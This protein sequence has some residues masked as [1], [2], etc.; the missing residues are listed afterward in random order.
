MS[1]AWPSR[2]RS[3]ARIDLQAIRDNVRALARPRRRR[4]PGDGGRQGRRL[5]PRARCRAPAP[6]SRAA[7]PGSAARSSRRRSPCA[8]AGIDVPLLAWLTTP[9]EDV[10]PAVA[11]GIDVAAYDRRR[12]STRSPRRRAR[13]V[14]R[15]ACSSRSTRGCPAAARRRATGPTCAPPRRR[16]EASGEVRVTGLWSHFAFADGGADHPVNGRQAAVFAEA[17][18]GR[19]PRRACARRCATSPTPPRP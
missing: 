15:R 18:D 19:R 8:R 16:A 6:R 2:M 7:P 3:E 11:A 5:R 9:G 14:R 13:P 4:R 12:S 10:A 17:L 1:A